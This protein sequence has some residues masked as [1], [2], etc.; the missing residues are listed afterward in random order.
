MTYYEDMLILL[1]QKIQSTVK[2][3]VQVFDA[4][5]NRAYVALGKFWTQKRAVSIIIK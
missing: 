5:T 2:D 3:V 4:Q 1:L